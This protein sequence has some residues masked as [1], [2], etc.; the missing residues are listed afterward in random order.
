MR[1]STQKNLQAAES[2]SEKV[3]IS[4]NEL[5][6]NQFYSQILKRVLEIAA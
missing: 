3:K 6:R 5:K 2:C 4:V 1:K